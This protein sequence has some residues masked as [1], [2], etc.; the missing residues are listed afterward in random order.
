MHT[1]NTSATA[2]VAAVKELGLDMAPKRSEPLR[3]NNASAGETLGTTADKVEPKGTNASSWSDPVIQMILARMQNLEDRLAR[4][5]AQQR[6]QK[7]GEE[8]TKR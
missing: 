3:R 2:N 6:D 5:E 8:G 1:T 4:L 7:G